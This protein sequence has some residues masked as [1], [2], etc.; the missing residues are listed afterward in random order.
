MTLTTEDLERLLKWASRFESVE[1][2]S[3]MDNGIW[4]AEDNRLEQRILDE[5]EDRKAGNA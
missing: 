1:D 3:E 4:I 5:L 2:T